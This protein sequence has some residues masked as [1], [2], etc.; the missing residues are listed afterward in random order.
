[1]ID[2]YFRTRTLSRTITTENSLQIT[3]YYTQILHKETIELAKN[4]K[5]SNTTKTLDT[6]ER[7][8]EQEMNKTIN[9]N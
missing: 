9:S 2:S 7:D 3:Q 6:D 4:S 1:M 5:D 8:N